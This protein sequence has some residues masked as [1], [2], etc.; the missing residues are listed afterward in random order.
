MLRV[1]EEHIRLT[2]GRSQAI[3]LFE[4]L[5]RGGSV[6][7]RPIEIEDESEQLVLWLL[8][9]QLEKLLVEPLSPDWPAIL[10]E[11]RAQVR[12]EAAG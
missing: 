1:A 4:V 8:E 3:V 6:P 9:A 10:R 7:A 12:G 5:T 2:L 11:A